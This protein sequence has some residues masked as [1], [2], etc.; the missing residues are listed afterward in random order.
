MYNEKVATTHL[1][2]VHVGLQCLGAMR[3]GDPITSSISAI[4][5]VLKKLCPSYEWVPPGPVQGQTYAPNPTSSASATPYSNGVAPSQVNPMRETFPGGTFLGGYLPTMPNIQVNP[6]Q[7]D[8][9]EVSASV[10]SSEDLPDFNLSDIGWDFDFSTM[11]LEAFFS[12]Q[13][14]MNPS[15]P[16]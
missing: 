7:S 2:W 5:T 1:P 6:L 12:I 8:I 9:P 11:D 16:L 4:Q 15:Q 14:T 3:P 13:P 10:G